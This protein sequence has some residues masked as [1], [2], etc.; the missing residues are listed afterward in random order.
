MRWMVALLAV[1][2]CAP[3]SPAPAVVPDKPAAAAPAPALI[4][5]YDA[6]LIIKL[7]APMDYKPGKRT[8]DTADTN[9]SIELTDPDGQLIKAEERHCASYTDGVTCAG[10][11][12]TG[13]IVTNKADKFDRLTYVN[14]FNQDQSAVSMFTED[15]DIV[16]SDDIILNG[17]VSEANFE[18]ALQAFS[19]VLHQ[20]RNF[21]LGP[22]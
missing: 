5:K 3:Q 18:A 12:L 9:P 17:G 20:H 11:T 13:R 19:T 8:E 1:A 4:D 10:I 15:G 16:V 22:R 6:D 7:M 14:K 21:L 2:A